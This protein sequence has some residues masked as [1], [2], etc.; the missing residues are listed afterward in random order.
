MTSTARHHLINNIDL[1]TNLST[2]AFHKIYLI[3]NNGNEEDIDDR[4]LKKTTFNTFLNR[5]DLDFEYLLKLHLFQNVQINGGTY[6]DDD[7]VNRIQLPNTFTSDGKA[8][9]FHTHQI[10]EVIQLPEQL[11]QKRNKTDYNFRNV[12]EDLVINGL[13]FKCSNQEKDLCVVLGEINKKLDDLVDSVFG[14][15]VISDFET[16]SNVISNFLNP[17]NPYNWTSNYFENSNLKN[18]LVHALINFLTGR[19]T[20]ALSSS[21]YAD[22]A[23]SN[24]FIPSNHRYMRKN[25]INQL[26]YPVYK[27]N[28]TNIWGHYPVFNR[29][30]F[31]DNGIQTFNQDDSI[32]GLISRY[33]NLTTSQ[34]GFNYKQSLILDNIP[35]EFKN[36]SKIALDTTAGDVFKITSGMYYW[37]DS[38][39]NINNL[40]ILNGVEKTLMILDDT[41]AY[42]HNRLKDYTTG[43]KYVLEDEV[44]GGDTTITKN[45]YNFEDNTIN[46]EIKNKTNVFFEDNRLSY[47]INKTVKNNVFYEDIN[48]YFENK[49]ITK[50]EYNDISTKNYF[51]NNYFENEETYIENKKSYFN[52]IIDNA[53][54]LINN[55]KKATNQ[56]TENYLLTTNDKKVILNN[57]SEQTN[58]ILNTTK[59]ISNNYT[60]NTTQNINRK[61]NNW[62]I[63]NDNQNIYYAPSNNNITVAYDDAAIYNYIGSLAGI[64]DNQSTRLTAAETNISIHN[65]RL[66]NLENV[67]ANHLAQLTGL[68]TRMTNAEIS[69]SNQNGRLVLVEGAINLMFSRLDNLE[70]VRYNIFD[71]PIQ[72]SISSVDNGFRIPPNTLTTLNWKYSALFGSTTGSFIN[73]G[74]YPDTGDSVIIISSAGFYE[75][76]FNLY[77]LK[78][79]ESWA[80]ADGYADFYL[81]EGSSSTAYPSQNSFYL[82]PA[83]FGFKSFSIFFN[84]STNDNSYITLKCNHNIQAINQALNGVYIKRN[85]SSLVITKL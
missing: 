32:S 83:D 62:Y 38:N 53:T 76:K 15:D 2:G 43:K 48:N 26:V 5:Y 23:D 30:A 40:S 20:N 82:P 8:D 75:F 84:K 7:T 73:I 19:I 61:T 42:F 79:N 69:I 9:K 31:S 57:I 24:Y 45:Y 77:F 68:T 64:V 66:N 59:Q 29:V 37:K 85:A 78:P 46:Y 21:S 50:N 44:G 60:E 18:G 58:Q 63:L 52:Q 72:T 28:N 49:Y 16:I 70:K 80:K 3:D 13:K 41:T 11:N 71:L 56:Y 55:T 17:V 12:S 47:D 54:Q 14:L 51:S 81:L 1:M 65:T 34:T 35:L 6:D 27:S 25:S 10:S 4:Y 22:T 67:Q 39:T 33:N 74:T 36:G